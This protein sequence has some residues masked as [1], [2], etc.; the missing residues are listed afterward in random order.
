MKRLKTKLRFREVVIVL[1]LGGTLIYLAV[2]L[3]LEHLMDY[4][5]RVLPPREAALMSGIVFGD[6]SGFDKSLNQDL[7]NSGLMHMVVISG[8]NLMILMALIINGLSGLLNRKIAIIIGILFTWIF[9]GLVGWQVS[10]LRAVLMV[11]LVYWAQ[12]LGRKFSILRSVGLVFILMVLID[13]QFLGEVSF[14]LSF[15]AYLGVV[16]SKGKWS[17]LWVTLWTMPVMAIYFGRVS[18]ISPISNLLVLGLSETVMVLG[19]TGVAMGQVIQWLGDGMLLILLPVLRYFLYV[20]QVFGQNRLAVAEIGF[21]VW[22]LTGWYMV[23]V[24]YS[25]LKERKE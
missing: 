11:S 17:V 8:A 20:A 7:K 9:V 10:I 16:A 3:K 19:L 4:I 6:K 23:L 21:N 22:M 14:W 1:F 18:L 12:L 24:S 15:T 13:Y 2:F 5:N 25:F